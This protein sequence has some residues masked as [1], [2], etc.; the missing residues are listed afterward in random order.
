MP[1][2]VLA[3]D[4]NAK[5]ERLAEAVVSVA[6][7]YHFDFSRVE[8]G[9]RPATIVSSSL[10]LSQTSGKLTIDQLFDAMQVAAQGTAEIAE[11][12]KNVMQKG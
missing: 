1:G 4:P 8:E 12:Q 10:L 9:E 5:E 11:L 7:P 6:N 3:L 2:S